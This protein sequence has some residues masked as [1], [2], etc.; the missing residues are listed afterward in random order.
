[1]LLCT[2]S[3]LE[4]ITLVCGY[5]QKTY[6]PKNIFIFANSENR[7][8]LYYTY[9]TDIRDLIEQTILVHRKQESNT[10]YTINALNDLIKTINNGVQ[11]QS[12][13]LNWELYKNSIIMM[14]NGSYTK[15]EIQLFKV[16]NSKN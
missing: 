10:I 5:I 9:N 2:F 8:Q 14:M 6:N 1:M 11:D 12:Y 7:N 16:I 13:V 4:D 15:I 3:R